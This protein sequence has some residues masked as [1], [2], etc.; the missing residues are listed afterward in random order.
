VERLDA[1]QLEEGGRDALA[2]DPFGLARARQ[3]K[4]LVGDGRD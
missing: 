2:A 1:E 3:V 4:A